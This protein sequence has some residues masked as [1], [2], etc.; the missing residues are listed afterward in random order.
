MSVYC[1]ENLTSGPNTLAD[2]DNNPVDMADWALYT[3]NCNVEALRDHFVVPVSNLVM[4]GYLP[5]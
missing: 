3:E 2:V 1:K 4:V 5:H